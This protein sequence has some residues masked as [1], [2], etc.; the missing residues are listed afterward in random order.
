MFT[1]P[2]NTCENVQ[3]GEHTHLYVCFLKVQVCSQTHVLPHESMHLSLPG[4]HSYLLICTDTCVHIWLFQHTHAQIDVFMYECR[5]YYYRIEGF[6]CKA[7]HT[8]SIKLLP[9]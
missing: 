7:S 8:H 4:M 6:A 2:K 9:S 1:Q 3:P 5:Q